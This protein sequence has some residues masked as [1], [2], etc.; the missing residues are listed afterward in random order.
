MKVEVVNQ[1]RLSRSSLCCGKYQ[2]SLL[3]SIWTMPVARMRLTYLGSTKNI[4][5]ASLS[6]L[7]AVADLFS[8]Y[9]KVVSAATIQCVETEC[10]NGTLKDVVMSGYLL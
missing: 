4:Q 8:G 1:K 10:F 3:F 9:K 7:V 6:K 2:D 5:K